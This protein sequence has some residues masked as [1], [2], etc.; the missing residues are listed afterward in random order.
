MKYVRARNTIIGYSVLLLTVFLIP[1]NVF[2]Y[3]YMLFSF[4]IVLI[5]GSWIYLLYYLYHESTSVMKIQDKN[6]FIFD[7]LY[8]L[9]L[10]IYF[11]ILVVLKDLELFPAT[12]LY[13]LHIGF[14]FIVAFIKVFLIKTRHAQI[15]RVS[16]VFLFPLMNIILIQQIYSIWYIAQYYS[17]GT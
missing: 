1:N 7:L 14:L 5:V 6:L 11:Y 16:V 8:I 3:G 15:I 13:Y 9:G 4:I 17:Q 10:P 2:E 12:W